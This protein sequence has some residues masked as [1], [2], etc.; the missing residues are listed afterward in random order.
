MEAVVI[1][2]LLGLAGLCGFMLYKD[3]TIVMPGTTV[4]PKKD[5]AES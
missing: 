2:V 4:P 5:D 3:G 1:V